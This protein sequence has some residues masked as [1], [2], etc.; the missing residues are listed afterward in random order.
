MLNQLLRR[1][2]AFVGLAIA[3]AAILVACNG[4]APSESTNPP[5]VVGSSPWP[6]FAGYYVALEKGFFREEGVEV[7]DTYFQIATDVN[8]RLLAGKLDLAWTGGP[9]VVVMAS[10]DPTLRLIML[11]DYS[12]GADGILARNVQGPEDLKG[13][14]I[15]WESLPLQALLLRKYLEQGGLTEKDVTLQILPAAAAATAFTA[16]QIDA[17]VTYE[18]YLSTAAKDGKGSIVFSSKGSNIIPVGLV[19]K[20]E[21]IQAR[22][23]EIRAFIRA[24]DRGVKEVRSNSG[25]TNAIVAKKLGVEP[26]AVLNQLATVHLFDVA[27]NKSIVFNS[28]DPLN[29]MD[30]L[31][32]A[33]KTSEEISLINT[34]VNADKLYDSTLI[35]GL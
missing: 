15:A 25:E 8:T 18:P 34:P 9:D 24:V 29:V 4:Q 5:L 7:T 20:E 22:Q 3:T 11:S 27:E 23:E 19:G 14:A 17:A 30:S 21:V 31:R 1:V 16:G 26:S 2:V 12:D 6:G 33:V 35:E 32:F 28:R 10:Q 13:R